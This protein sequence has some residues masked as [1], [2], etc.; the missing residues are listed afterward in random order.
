MNPFL[1]TF[2][3]YHLFNI[4]TGKAANDETSD[5]LLNVEN[6]GSRS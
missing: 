2:D 4:S 5:F 6:I 3:K 1:N